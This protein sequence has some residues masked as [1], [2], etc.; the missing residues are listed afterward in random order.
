MTQA[1]SR[2][3][4]EDVIEPGALSVTAFTQWAGLAPSTVWDMISK[5]KIHSVKRGG[6]RLI[7]MESAKA[8]LTGEQA[9]A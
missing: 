9:A 7:P 1:G 3:R 6:R 2:I 4:Q 8:W 5:G